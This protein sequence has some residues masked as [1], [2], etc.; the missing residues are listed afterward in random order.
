M[1]EADLAGEEEA[2]GAEEDV[3]EGTEIAATASQLHKP[4]NKTQ[5]KHKYP[6]SPAELASLVLALPKTPTEIPKARTRVRRLQET[7]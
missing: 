5:H 1:A 4:A 2:E 7:M 6:L 3:G